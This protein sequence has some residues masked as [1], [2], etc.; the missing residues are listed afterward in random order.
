MYCRPGRPEHGAGKTEA[1]E[2]QV[3]DKDEKYRQVIVPP[4]VNNLSLMHF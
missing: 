4:N 1:D 3:D 2:G